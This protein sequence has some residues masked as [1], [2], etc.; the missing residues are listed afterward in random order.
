MV[1][2]IIGL[3]AFV[4][5]FIYDINSIR[6]E[7]RIAHT[8][9]FAG[10]CMLTLCTILMIVSACTEK[11]ENV[12]RSGYTCIFAVLSAVCLF[13]MVYSLFFALPFDETY[14]KTD[15]KPKVCDTGMYA[16]CRH[17]GVLWF[18]LFYFFMAVALRD[19]TFIMSSTVYSLCNIAYGLFEDCYIFPKRFEDYDRYKKETPMFIPTPQ[20]IKKALKR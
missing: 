19:I 4:F 6:W 17:P 1:Y 13:L 9:F 2:I 7:N 18:C 11:N 14:V 10:T 15:S 8:L 3:I 20:S 16:I 12:F 5:Y